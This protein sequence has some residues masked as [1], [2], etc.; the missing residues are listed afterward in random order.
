VR[1][2]V[3]SAAAFLAISSSIL[4]GIGQQ[5]DAAQSCIGGGC[6]GLLAA[7]TAC[8]NDAEVIYTKVIYNGSAA[9]GYIQLK[10][11]PSCRAAWGRVISNLSYGSEAYV[12][13]NAGENSPNC[14]G[15]WTAGTGCNTTMIDDDASITP[16][17][18]ACAVGD[19]F[20]NASEK[21][22]SAATSCF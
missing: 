20:I 1:K 12:G 7:N 2:L 22:V 5:A 4:I 13:N 9:V 10:Y 17:L 15:S 11:S 18:V 19:V 16:N 3:V 6:N 14:G 21:A 8:V